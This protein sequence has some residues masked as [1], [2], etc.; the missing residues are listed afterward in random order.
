VA[1][2]DSSEVI[3]QMMTLKADHTKFSFE[4]FFPF[5]MFVMLVLVINRRKGKRISRGRKHSE[6]KE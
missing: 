6:R 1:L 5:E 3:F 4:F 2:A